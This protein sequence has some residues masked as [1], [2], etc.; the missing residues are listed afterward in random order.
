MG[1]C[2]SHTW[3][4]LATAHPTQTLAPIIPKGHS[5]GISHVK[6]PNLLYKRSDIYMY[7]Y[8]HSYDETSVRVALSNGNK[9]KLYI[10]LPRR[11]WLID[12]NT[13]RPPG[14]NHPRV[15][16]IECITLLAWRRTHTH[17]HNTH[18]HAHNTHAFCKIA[19]IYIALLVKIFIKY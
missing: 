4:Y 11:I 16:S 12:N 5:L 10:S 13:P 9:Y 7:T 6:H 19:C 8:I 1:H 2:W 17:T 15:V 14:A 3:L 18:A